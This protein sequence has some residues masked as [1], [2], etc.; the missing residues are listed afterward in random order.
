[1][2]DI[3]FSS[4]TGMTAWQILGSSESGGTLY[5]EAVNTSLRALR[6]DDFQES[7]KQ[8]HTEKCLSMRP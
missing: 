4:S 7:L 8:V 5:P 1:M 3:F 2:F 6:L